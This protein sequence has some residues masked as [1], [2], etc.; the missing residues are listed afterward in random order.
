MNE[1]AKFSG[2]FCGWGLP[3]FRPCA[4]V[5]RYWVWVLGWLDWR[6]TAPHAA[7]KTPA[8]GDWLALACWGGQ[9]VGYWLAVG[10]VGLDRLLDFFGGGVKL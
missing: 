4:R 2:F 6:K 5:W 3:C 9:P 1:P 7:L 10:L 8:Y